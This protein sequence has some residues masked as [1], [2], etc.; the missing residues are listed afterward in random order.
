MIECYLLLMNIK[1]I[2]GKYCKQKNKVNWSF[3]W[4]V[5]W[6]NFFLQYRVEL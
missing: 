1:N 3:E 4:K 6:S 2:V 5:L